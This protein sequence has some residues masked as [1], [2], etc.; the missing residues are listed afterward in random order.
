VTLWLHSRVFLLGSGPRALDDFSSFNKV[1]EI[2]EYF[3]D[4][5]IS[6]LQQYA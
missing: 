5:K 1:K 2:R 3:K 6:K 4:A